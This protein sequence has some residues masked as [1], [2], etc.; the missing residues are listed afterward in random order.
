MT[1]DELHPVNSKS[2]FAY[3]EI[4]RSI[5]E[6]DFK[7][8]TLLVERRLSELLGISR[9]SIRQGLHQLANEGFVEYV[10]NKG[11]FVADFNVMDAIEIYTIRE[12]TDPLMLENCFN[13]N[14]GML[15]TKLE[16]ATEN[17]DKAIRE[18]DYES[19]IKND[20]AYHNAYIETCT[21]KRLQ[22]FVFSMMEQVVRFAHMNQDFDRALKSA[23]QHR[24]IYEAYRDKDIEKAKALM[25]GHMREVRAYY[26]KKIS[27][28]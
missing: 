21:Y 11:V 5:V 8:N 15:L 7:P 17:I 3:Q 9:T 12:V 24:A 20:M 1:N 18:N 19:Y 6:N 26:I 13:F 28:I 14:Y 16:V 25:S 10:V 22:N 2:Q 23:M 27:K 4:K